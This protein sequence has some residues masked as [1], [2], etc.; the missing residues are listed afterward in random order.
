MFQVNFLYYPQISLLFLC[1]DSETLSSPA[2]P[3]LTIPPPQTSECWIII[4]WPHAILF[5]LILSSLPY[6]GLPQCH[7]FKLTMHI[8]THTYTYICKPTHWPATQTHTSIHLHTCAHIC[9][10]ICTCTTFKLFFRIVRYILLFSKDKEVILLSRKSA[11]LQIKRCKLLGSDY[12]S[13]LMA[14]LLCL[15]LMEFLSELG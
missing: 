2:G 3:V 1:F 4:M 12:C 11:N 10:N 13:L 5:L 9:R 15:Y 14:H 7:W 8:L 6:V